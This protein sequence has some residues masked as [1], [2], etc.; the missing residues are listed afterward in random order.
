[1]GLFLGWSLWAAADAGVGAR[2]VSAFRSSVTDDHRDERWL[3]LGGR[4]N[5]TNIDEFQM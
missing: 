1:M 2:Q 5:G 4:T 3:W